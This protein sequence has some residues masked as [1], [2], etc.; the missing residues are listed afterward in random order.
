MLRLLSNS[1][2]LQTCVRCQ[3]IC[4]HGI[5]FGSAACRICLQQYALSAPWSPLDAPVLATKGFGMLLCTE[6]WWVLSMMLGAEA[7]QAVKH[8]TR[9][10]STKIIAGPTQCTA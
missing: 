7:I 2:R 1:G 10:C 3:L 9:H 6:W 5:C 4:C 8:I